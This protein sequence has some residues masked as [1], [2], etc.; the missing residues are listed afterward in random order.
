MRGASRALGALLF[1]V[2]ALPTPAQA[3]EWAQI[4]DDDGIKVWRRSVEG[5]DFV[6]FRGRGNVKAPIQL[7]AAVIRDADRETEWME[8]CVDA[9]TVRFLT[10]TDAIVY[11]RTGS[12]VPFIADRDTVLKTTTAVFPEKRTVLVDF[13]NTTDSAAPP[14]DGVVRMPTLKGHWRLVQLDPYTTEVEYQ[15][16]ADPGGALPAW[17]VNMVSKKLP[18]HTVRRL[19]GQV[20]QGGYEQHRAIL[21]VAIDWSGFAQPPPQDTL[22]PAPTAQPVEVR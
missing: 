8:N 12:P 13:N 3:G 4:D 9:K 7:V 22:R 20:G 11:H 19:R 15:V 21:E 10:A 18:F 16:Q 6:V 14:K 5:S 2:M 1:T 17:L